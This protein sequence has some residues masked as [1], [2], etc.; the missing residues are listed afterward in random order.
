[1][2]C[3]LGTSFGGRL[4]S[5]VGIGWAILAGGGGAGSAWAGDRLEVNAL[6]YPWSAVGRLNAAG[7]GH[8]TGTLVGERLVL[9]A[10][11]CVYDKARNRWRLPSEMHFV[12]GYQRGDHP[13][14]SAVKT[15]VRAD[16]FVYNA[17]PAAKA[18][19]NDWALLELAE[20]LGRLAGWLGVEPLTLALLRIMRRD[21]APVVLAGYR[22]DRAH[23]ITIDRT[24]ELSGFLEGVPQLAI[25]TCNVLHGDSGGP[26]MTFMAGEIR[27]I[28]VHVVSMTTPERR[29]GGAVATTVLT[30]QRTWPQAT[31]AA[32]GFGLRLPSAGQIPPKGGVATPVP[33]VSVAA[34]LNVNG[35]DSSVAIRAAETAHGLTSTGVASMALLGA[36]L[37]ALIKP[38]EASPPK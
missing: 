3:F 2:T 35:G 23:I 20:P 15:I 38:P 25:H 10:A 7:H 11:H 17:H 24:C 22:A 8:C 30:D 36:L 14:H 27:V 13:L 31:A 34:L 21:K 16:D 26:V 9:T 29:Y 5:A 37:G 28:G 19:I 18:E 33:A 32:T 1:M 6:E 4:L 12:A